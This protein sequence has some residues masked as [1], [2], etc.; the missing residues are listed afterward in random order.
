LPQK[1]CHGGRRIHYQRPQSV[2]LKDEAEEA[3]EKKIKIKNRAKKYFFFFFFS[4]LPKKDAQGDAVYIL[5][6]LIVF[7]KRMKQKRLLKVHPPNV[8]RG[9]LILYTLIDCGRFS[10]QVSRLLNTGIERQ[11]QYPSY[12]SY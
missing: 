2:F 4:K 11:H 3:A 9:T 5:S 10:F 6:A 1:R 12:T 8:R 7:L